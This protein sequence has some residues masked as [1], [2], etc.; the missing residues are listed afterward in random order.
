MGIISPS[1]A[2]RADSKKLFDKGVENLK[3]FGLDVCISDHFYDNEYYK[4][5][6][7]ENRLSDIH[8][9][10]ANPE[11]KMVMMAVG[12]CYANMLLE[13]IDYSLIKA[14]PKIFTGMSDGS[15]LTN[16]IYQKTGLV[17]FYG[18]NMQDTLGMNLSE[19][20]RENFYQTLFVGE[21]IK[22]TPNEHLSIMPWRSGASSKKTYNG[23]NVIKPGKASGRL[24]GGYLS[25]LITMDYAGFRHDM[26]DAILF[27]ESTEDANQIFVYLSSLKQRGVFDQ[28][29]GMIVGYHNGEEDQAEI[30]GVV[31]DVTKGY[32]FPIIQIGELGHDTENYCFP[33]GVQ[34]TLDTSHQMISID[35]KVTL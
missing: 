22:L 13:H 9:F 17:T 5:A 25:R 30:A 23:W 34:A 18:I 24:I 27:F 32:N 21:G 16:A 26:K 28:I 31:K 7:L 3:G 1:K 15:L 8:G 4:G 35:E 20:M 29:K 33:M 10:F 6:T 19:K 2:P 11:I 14:N 12:G